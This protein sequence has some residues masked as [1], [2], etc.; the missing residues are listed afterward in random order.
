ME[1]CFL[2]VMYLINCALHNKKA[3]INEDTDVARVV[4]ECYAQS[5]ELLA[6]SVLVSAD[7][8]DALDI[9]PEMRAYLMKK[10]AAETLR[11]ARLYK[12]IDDLENN[13]FDPIII[14][15]VTLADLYP[16]PALRESVDTDLLFLNK[17]RCDAATRFLIG[18]GGE[19]LSVKDTEKHN[20]VQYPGVGRVELHHCLYNESF[21]NYRLKRENVVKQPFDRLTLKDGKRVSALGKTDALKFVFCHMLGHFIYNRCDLKQ[22]C[23]ILLYVRTYKDEIDKAELDAFLERTGYAKA[24]SAVMGAGVE[25]LGFERGELINAD[26]SPRTVE[27]FMT[28]CFNG[29]T[30]GVWG[31]NPRGRRGGGAASA[32]SL[33]LGKKSFVKKVVRI[34]VAPEKTVLQGLYPYCA[35]N[36]ALLPAAWLNNIVDL[37]LGALRNRR[38][39]RGR[40]EVLKNIG[41]I[42]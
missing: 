12:M 8:S 9:L 27:L 17:E 37:S 29:C 31:K 2:D 26:C 36:P 35:E 30:I 4:Q 1:Q 13:G 24:F 40:E 21:Y 23:D 14:K 39:I 20:T 28:D 16:N 18:R 33:N 34:G 42:D 15:G 32:K 3:H 7:N 38:K 10:T 11:R 25:Y 22:I 19:V 41:V 5:C 6:L